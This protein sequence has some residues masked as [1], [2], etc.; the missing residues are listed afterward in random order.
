MFA[1]ANYT[2]TVH[3]NSQVTFSDF[4]NLGQYDA[5]NLYGHG[6][7][8]PQLGEGIYTSI[9]SSLLTS[10]AN[11]WDLLNDRLVIMNGYYVV[12]PNYI[13]AYAGAMNG[14]IVEFEACNS[15]HDTQLGDAL[16]NLGAGAYL[17]YSQTVK[18][19][20]AAGKRQPFEP[21]RRDYRSLIERPPALR[22][23][24]SV[25]RAL[26]AAP[27]ASR[28][29]RRSNPTRRGRARAVRFQF[30]AERRGPSEVGVPVSAGRIQS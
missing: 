26:A 24:P 28:L 15:L 29:R 18:A 20:F 9:Q 10:A 25:A 21:E 2:V 8:L 4:A 27:F 7:Q 16:V 3:Q 11:V 30:G 13:S 23:F 14:T 22:R 12:T 1:N 5:V 6:T 19:T 17:G